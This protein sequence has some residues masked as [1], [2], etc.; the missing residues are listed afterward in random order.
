[1]AVNLIKTWEFAENS[2][3]FVM[4]FSFANVFNPDVLLSDYDIHAHL[5]L[6]EA[7]DEEPVFDANTADGSFVITDDT[8]KI[9]EIIIPFEVIEEKFTGGKK[10]IGDLLLINKE[11]RTVRINAGRFAMSVTD[12]VT[13]GVE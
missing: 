10:W 5:K 12:A 6:T 2:A 11:F 8:Q 4:R 7:E 3:P 9:A 1:M 13:T